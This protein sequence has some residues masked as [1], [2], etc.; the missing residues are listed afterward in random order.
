MSDTESSRRLVAVSN[1]L[2]VV[3]DQE[4]GRWQI[5][6]GAGGLV[7]ALAPVM[8]ARGGLWIGWPGCGEEA[9]LEELVATFEREQ[10]F[11]LG[12]VPL[13]AEEVEK[14]YEGF[15][16][17]TLWPLFHDLLGHCQ[18][19]PVNWQAYQQVNRRFAEQT[20]ARLA[21]GKMLS[22][23]VAAVVAGLARM[24]HQGS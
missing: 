21:A 14:Y 5:S 19:S 4:E 16:N 23:D 17:E 3:I 15:S 6:P 13:T 1:R 11:Q 10:G 7:T 22:S 12:P 24:I 2:P 9:P 20:A 18:F 8:R